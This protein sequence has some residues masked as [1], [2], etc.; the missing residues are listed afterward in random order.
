MKAAACSWRQL[1]HGGDEAAAG[2]DEEVI[3]LRGVDVV[4]GVH[5]VAPLDHRPAVAGQVH[6]VEIEG[7]R[8]RST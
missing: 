5:E 1:G 6:V 7:R 3:D 2:D 4:A 8:R